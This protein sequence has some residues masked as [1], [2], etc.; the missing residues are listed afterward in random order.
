MARDDNEHVFGLSVGKA[1]EFGLGNRIAR[2]HKLIVVKRR[3]A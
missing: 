1:T 2:N 3:S